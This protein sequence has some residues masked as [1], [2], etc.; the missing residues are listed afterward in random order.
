MADAA[1]HLLSLGDSLDSLRQR[2]PVDDPQAIEVLRAQ[3]AAYSL[4]KD[5]AGR[6]LAPATI[7]DVDEVTLKVAACRPA[8]GEDIAALL[9]DVRRV[10]NRVRNEIDQD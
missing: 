9:A 3:I 1:P 10:L 4:A 2:L 5:A 8:P 7:R 6:S